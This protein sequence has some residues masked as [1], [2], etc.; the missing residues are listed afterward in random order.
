MTST[1]ANLSA[2]TLLIQDIERSRTFYSD[3]FGWDVIWQDDVSIGFNTGNC[4]INLLLES[5]G[6]DLIA[7]AAVGT[8]QDGQRVMFSIFVEN[9]V[10]ELERLASRGIQPINGPIDRPW[11]MRTAC[12]VDPDGYV[13][14]LAQNIGEHLNVG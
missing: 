2:V 8:A 13:W 4:I 9:T 6:T 7:P 3:G 11:G 14:E 10:A 12:V 1:R 5:Q